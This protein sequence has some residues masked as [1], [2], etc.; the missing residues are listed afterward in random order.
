MRKTLHLPSSVKPRNRDKLYGR[1]WRK[2]RRQFLTEHPLCVMCE[3]DGRVVPAQEVDHIKKHGGNPELFFDVDN[4]QGL[5]S[6]HH[7]TVKA[8][9]ERSGRARGHRADGWP[10]DP[11]H[12][13]IEAAKADQQSE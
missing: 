3:V 10:I 5:C 4:L 11:E 13:W 12:Y 9:M 1:R 2:I 6:W 8:Q 7:R